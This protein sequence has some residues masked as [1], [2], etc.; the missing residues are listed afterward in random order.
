MFS[1]QQLQNSHNPQ[2]QDMLIQ[3]CSPE[4]KQ[5]RVPRPKYG[6]KLDFC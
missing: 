3:S 5:A 2:K 1:K 6:E 4:E